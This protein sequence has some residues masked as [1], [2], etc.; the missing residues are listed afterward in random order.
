MIGEPAGKIRTQHTTHGLPMKY[1]APN[2]RIMPNAENPTM[3][4]LRPTRSESAETAKL[5][6]AAEKPRVAMSHLA[7]LASKPRFAVRYNGMKAQQHTR[8]DTSSTEI[9]AQSCTLRLAMAEA[10]VALGSGPA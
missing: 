8:Y 7:V 2:G 5:P 6:K 10:M 1:I 4:G 9:N 3:T